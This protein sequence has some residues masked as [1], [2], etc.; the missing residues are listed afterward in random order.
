FGGHSDL[1]PVHAAAAAGSWPHPRQHQLCLRPERL[2]GPDVGASRRLGDRVVAR[3]A[4]PALCADTSASRPPCSRGAADRGCP[5]TLASIA[6]SRRL[7]MQPLAVRFAWRELRGAMRGFYV[8]IACIALGVMAIAGVG[9][10]AA[11][12]ADGLARDGRI[13]LGGDL[14]MTLSQREA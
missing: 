3:N 10:F 8:F 14:S 5:M 1:F 9:S 12:L 7:P 11:S 13:I 2:R 4:A 6:V